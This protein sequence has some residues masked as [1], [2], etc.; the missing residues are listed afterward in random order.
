MLVQNNQ[1]GCS[2]M[3]FCW[4]YFIHMIML[5]HNNQVGC[6]NMLFCWK[7]FRSL[8][9]LSSQEVKVIKSTFYICNYLFFYNRRE[10]LPSWKLSP[11]NFIKLNVDD[12]ISCDFIFLTVVAKNANGEVLKVW[13]KIY[14]L[15]TLVQVE[16]A[17]I[18]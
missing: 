7:Y 18:L 2:N 3:L 13:T 8:N 15:C 4:K 5:V 6:S 14:D 10:E 11:R 17:P 16:A 9:K 1:V 12:A